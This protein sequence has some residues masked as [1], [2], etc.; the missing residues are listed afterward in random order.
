[1]LADPTGAD[2]EAPL[3]GLIGN[4]PR[5][6]R[7]WEQAV[8]EELG[9]RFNATTYQE[10]LAGYHAELDRRIAARGMGSNRQSGTGINYARTTYS[11]VR[12][13]FGKLAE[14]AGISL[15]GL[16]VHHTFDEL[17]KNPRGALDTTNLGFQRGH[18]GKVGTG[19][20]FAHE[21]NRALEAGSTNPGQTVANDLH[22]RGIQPDVPELAPSLRSHSPDV[23]HTSTPHTPSVHTPRAPRAPRGRVKVGG[24]W[25]LLIGAGIAT[26][27]LADTGDAYAAV[28]S[29]NPA[30]ETTDALVSE[31]RSA[32]GV[33]GGVALDIFYW[34]PPGWIVSAELAIYHGFLSPRGDNIY[35]QRLTDR[36]IAEGRNPFCAQCHGP[37][38]ALDPN[39]EWNRRSRFGDL[40]PAT[41]NTDV[42]REALM[43]WIQQS[44]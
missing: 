2:G 44:Q 34:T 41:L 30:A 15:Q 40:A 11:A 6:G 32:G 27:V 39:N 36:A 31:D 16:Q 23:P 1:M 9:S 24:P 26:Y 28:Q 33:A 4:D 20:N 37:G 3:P 12:T 10:A 13:R 29:V 25:G 22:Q 7:L 21:V 5:V 18:A 8:V 17:A 35:D 43:N 14:S 38:G 19:H 42:D